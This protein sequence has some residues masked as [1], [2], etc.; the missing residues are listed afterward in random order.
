[1]IWLPVILIIPYIIILLK[2]FP[3]LSRVEVY[4]E[5]GNPSVS[6]SVIVACH[7]EEQNLKNLL[8]SL[9][10]QD[11]PHDFLEVIIVNDNSTDKTFEIA[12][13]FTG[14]QNI[15]IINNS[16]AGKKSAIRTGVSVSNAELIITT[17]ADCSMGKNWIKIISSFYK[18]SKPDMIICPVQIE[19]GN[20]FFRRFQELEFLS[21]QG[22]TAGAAL[23][24]QAIMCN[25]ANLAFSREVYLK[26]SANLHDEINSGDDIFLLQSLKQEEN[27]KISWLES[28]EAIVT[29]SAS[30]S[31]SSFLKQRKRWI[32]KVAFYTDK[33]IITAGIATFAAVLLQ[34]AYLIAGLICPVLLIGFLFI[35]LLKSVPD[36]L[37]IQ[38]TAKRYGKTGLMKWFLPSQLIYPFYVMMVVLR[39][40]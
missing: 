36:Y 39:R 10:L 11:Y 2:Y 13:Q 19:T 9:S 28:P 7:N 29:T 26:H 31:V 20:G 24:D 35:F 17:D 12:S 1:M 30:S 25:G 27:S 5:S 21:L 22:I 18:Q 37:I 15:R 8:N 32:S 34:F 40:G 16:G 23:S 3:G 38:N 6:V 14:I 33:N 4:K